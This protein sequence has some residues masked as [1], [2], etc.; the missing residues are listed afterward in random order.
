MKKLFALFAITILVASNQSNAQEFYGEFK[1][2][3]VFSI[4]QDGKKVCYIT[5]SPTKKKGNYNRRGE[6]YMLVTLRENGITEVSV[7]SGYPFKKNSEVDIRVD[8]RHSYE[9]FTSEETPEMAW[10][11]DSTTDK[12]V[13]NKMKAG[14]KLT[15]KG[16]SRLG[17]YSLDT[18]SLAGFTAAFRKMKKIC[19]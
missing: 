7:N 11:K 5:S 13:I 8:G 9:F 19:D 15:A 17:T 2:W 18:Y 1:A 4:N 16:Y 10:A 12:Q 3:G 6:P 14:L